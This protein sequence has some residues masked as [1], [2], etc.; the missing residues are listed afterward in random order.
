MAAE[1]KS[2]ELSAALVDMTDPVGLARLATETG[3]V[4][5]ST[6]LLLKLIKAGNDLVRRR[7][8]TINRRLA[9]LMEF[10]VP[11]NE[12]PDRRG[13]SSK[14]AIVHAQTGS[15]VRVFLPQARAVNGSLTSEDGKGKKRRVIFYFHGGGFAVLAADLFSYDIFCRRLCRRSEA[16]VISVNYRRAPEHRYPVAYD[17]CYAALEWLEG[18]N[19][20]L[21]KPHELDLSQCVLMGDSAG[22]NIVHH[23][24]CRW[25]ARDEKPEIPP[26]STSNSSPLP[27]HQVKIVAHVLLFPYFGGEERT[28]SELRLNTRKDLLVSVEN[29]DWHWRAF[30]PPNSNRDHPASNVLGPNAPD[31]SSLQLPPSLIVIAEYDMLKDWQLRYAQGLARASKPVRLLYYVGGVHSFHVASNSKLTSHMLSDIVSFMNDGFD[32]QNS[33]AGC[34]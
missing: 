25:A 12:V 3:S 19:G 30:L 14:D 15:W 2:M 9:D 31:P 23:V 28:P 7:D 32:K 4:P 1:A 10:K 20:D 8:G 16:V 34:K 21:F 13:I 22:A 18:F 33:S 24:G 6:R 11:A 5:L 27:S 17:D 29:M 26:P